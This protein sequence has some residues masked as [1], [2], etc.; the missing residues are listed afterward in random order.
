MIYLKNIS[1]PQVLL[2]PNGRETGNVLK[3]S[4][5]NTID[6]SVCVENEVIDL[7]SDRYVQFL[8]ELPA[9]IPSGEYEYSLTDD[10]GTISTGLLMVE[11]DSDPMEYNKPIQYEQYKA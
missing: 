8:V 2:V 3:F 1:T 9:G 11:E 4:M 10:A 7:Q 6:K 5:R